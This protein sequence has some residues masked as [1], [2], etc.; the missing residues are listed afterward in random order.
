MQFRLHFISGL[1][2]QYWMQVRAIMVQGVARYIVASA[3][4]RG[5]RQHVWQCRGA[6]GDG[7]ERTIEMEGAQNVTAA[8]QGVVRR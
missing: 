3:T 7:A 6:T 8:S 4:W 1:A 2:V 5:R